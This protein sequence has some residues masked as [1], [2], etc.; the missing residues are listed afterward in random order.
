M[1]TEN[2]KTTLQYRVAT[3]RNPKTGGSL[4]RPYVTNRPTL[5]LKQI[6]SYAKTAGYVRGQQKDLE[7]LLGGFTEAMK[8][9]ALAGYAINVNN[10]YIISGQ[11][12]GTVGEDR[13]LSAKNSY[14]VTIT[15]T[16]DLKA[17]IDDFNW[18][19]VDE[20]AAIKVES[21]TSP[22]GNKNEITK[23]K[24]IIANGK[25]LAYNAAFGDSVK[26]SWLDGTTPRE[27]TLTPSE[28][29]ETYLRFD[30]PAGLAEVEAGTELTFSFRL[31]GAAEAAEQTSTVT[32]KLISA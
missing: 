11:L 26:V 12:K 14:H 30:W 29:S 10:W 7:G 17:S 19:R 2:D 13:Q 9:R 25:H 3:V 23:T 1:A 18:S 32:A 22:D 27:L 20:G 5:N 16:K 4:R 24:A 8:D 21:I 28:Q 6:V 31:H 15:A